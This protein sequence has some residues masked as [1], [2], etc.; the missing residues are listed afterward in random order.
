MA[1]EQLY[2]DAE[3]EDHPLAADMASRLGLSPVVIDD[4][5]RL[6]DPLKME[7]DPWSSGKKA[8]LLTR[9]RGAF[10]K[11]CPGTREY[12]CCGYQILHIGTYCTMDCSYCILQSY[13]H[14][15]LLHYF[16]NQDDLLDELDEALQ[17]NRIQ[18]FGTGEFT[19][20]LIW[21]PWTDLSSRLIQR[22]A[23]Q[24]RAVLEFKTKTTA[25][26]RFEDVQSNRKTILSWSLNTPHVI[27]TQE[28]GTATLE[29]RLRAAAKAQAWGYPL[30]F[31]F[32]PMVIYPGCEDHYR[33]VLERLVTRISPENIVWIS[34]GTFRFIPALKS[35][36]QKRFAESD[37]IHG[38]FVPG[39]DG[40]MRYFKPLRI[41]LYS[42][43]VKWLR[44]L[45]P[46]VTTYLC[47]EDEQIWELVY[48]FT[49]VSK[50]GLD[51]MLDESARI[52]CA[53]SD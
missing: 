29:A 50:G 2:V 41:R 28:R 17:Q 11:A 9:N 8:L 53:L 30:A 21:E 18:R 6:F 1:I 31:H 20:S 47:M 7:D 16:I 44:E 48:G 45:A 26:S 3:L 46:K 12:I 43:M 35:V 39:L 52:H 14:P 19:D 34:M 38:E 33:L 27:A 36:I 42:L 40:K 24:T 15:P 49:P 37:I 10:I 25:I 5:S 4:R 13:F 32:D 51:R 22:F 23:V